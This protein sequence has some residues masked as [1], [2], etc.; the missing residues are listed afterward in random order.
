MSATEAAAA[1]FLPDSQLTG[2]LPW[3]WPFSVAVFYD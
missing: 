3:I 2:K 1:L